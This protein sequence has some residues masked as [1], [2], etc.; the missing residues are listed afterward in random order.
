MKP[1]CV[2]WRISEGGEGDEGRGERVGEGVMVM[3]SIFGDFLKF[4]RPSFA[5]CR[6]QGDAHAKNLRCTAHVW[7]MHALVGQ[8]ACHRRMYRSGGLLAGDFTPAF[9]HS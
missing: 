9:M 4:Q 5:I 6:A 8:P 7:F 1:D 3:E 2:G